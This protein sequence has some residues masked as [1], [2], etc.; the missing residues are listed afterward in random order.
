MRSVDPSSII[1]WERRRKLE[2]SYAP[3]PAAAHVNRHWPRAPEPV[4]LGAPRLEGDPVGVK[5]RRDDTLGAI[6]RARMNS[7][8]NDV[9]TAIESVDLVRAGAMHRAAC[10][11]AAEYAILIE[12]PRVSRPQT[13]HSAILILRRIVGR[14]GFC[15]L[16]N[17]CKSSAS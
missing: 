14:R 8:M 6:S 7:A 1:R 3:L 13:W 11:H 4:P 16:P 9:A 15:A 10:F 5:S 2:F 17:T 12:W